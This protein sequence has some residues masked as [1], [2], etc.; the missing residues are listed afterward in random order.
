MSKDSML[1]LKLSI[2]TASLIAAI[3][4]AF[5]QTGN[6][7]S[8]LVKPR[9]PVGSGTV[10]LRAARLIDGTGAAPI[11]N[12]VIVVTDEKISAVGAADTVKIP[13]N[14]KVIDLGDATLLPGF[15]DVHTHLIGRVLGDP[16]VGTSMLKTMS[17]SARF[18]G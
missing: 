18:S 8:G 11:A 15:I 14:A 5:A 12:A 7:T 17:H 13:D 1:K 3:S 16:D 4:I 10:V 9:P 2:A 6:Q